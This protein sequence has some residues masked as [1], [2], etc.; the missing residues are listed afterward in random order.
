MRGAFVAICAAAVLAGCGQHEAYDYPA[1]A[2]AQFEA[3]CPPS[4]KVCAC[5]WDQITRS[6]TYE[7]Y[8]AA[9]TRYNERGLMDP[10]VTHART[11][12]LERGER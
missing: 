7:D 4:S 5:T 12:C 9:L 10:R 6:M 1:P 8:Q 3:S 2:R 11:V